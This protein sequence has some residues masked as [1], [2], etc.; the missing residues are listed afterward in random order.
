LKRL[1]VTVLLL[2]LAAW[3][4]WCLWLG[5]QTSWWTYWLSATLSLG[6]LLGVALD[7]RWSA[8]LTVIVACLP[9]SE[10]LLSVILSLRMGYF[11]HLRAAALLAALTPGLGITTLA[12]CSCVIAWRFVGR[13]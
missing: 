2:T 5:L 10:W 9:V 11:S 8:W 7:R 13:K 4:A 3:A 6:A 1:P 12:G